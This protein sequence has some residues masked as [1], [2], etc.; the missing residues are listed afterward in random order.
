MYGPIAGTVIS[1]G[2]PIAVGVIAGFFSC[3]YFKVLFK[4]INQNR[5]HDSLGLF[6]FVFVAFLGTFVIAPIVLKTYYNYGVSLVT[7][8]GTIVNA[9]SSGWILIYVGISVGIGLAG[10]LILGALMKCF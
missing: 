8:G 2:A 4:R 7:L 1:T 6:S 5:I 3:L 10:G 9:D